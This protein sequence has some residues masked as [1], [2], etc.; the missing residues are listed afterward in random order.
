[1]LLL[2][3]FPCFKIGFAYQETP[4]DLHRTGL[5]HDAPCGAPVPELVSGEHIGDGEELRHGG[6]VR[7]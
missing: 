3:R 6:Q 2:L 7:F 1:L 4:G 5:V